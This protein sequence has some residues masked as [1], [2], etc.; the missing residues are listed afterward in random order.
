[1]EIS[2]NVLAVLTSNLTPDDCHLAL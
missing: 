2:K 1:V